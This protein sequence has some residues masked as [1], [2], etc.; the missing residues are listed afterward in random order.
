M[1][2]AIKLYDY[3]IVF[4]PCL[5]CFLCPP[6]RMQ[7]YFMCNINL[8]YAT[9]IRMIQANSAHFNYVALSKLDFWTRFLPIWTLPLNTLYTV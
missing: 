4:L 5:S 8:I 9:N 3:H 6:S 2:I 7:R 1:I